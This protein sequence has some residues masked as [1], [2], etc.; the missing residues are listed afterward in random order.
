MKYTYILALNHITESWK[1]NQYYVTEQASSKGTRDILCLFDEVYWG[2]LYSN[3]ITKNIPNDEN[4]VHNLEILSDHT[5]YS[6]IMTVVE[7]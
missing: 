7:H 2:G 3:Y 6:Y 4:H 1:F 5:D